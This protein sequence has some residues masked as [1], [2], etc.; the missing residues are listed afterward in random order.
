MRTGIFVFLL[1]IGAKHQ[2]FIT[3]VDVSC[4]VLIDVLYQIKEAPFYSWF[5]ECFHHEK[6]LD[7]VKYFS[8]ICRG[9]DVVFFP[10][11]LFHTN[12]FLDLYLPCI[13]GINPIWSWYILLF[14]CC[15]IQL[16]SIFLRILASVFL[17]D[18][19]LYKPV[20]F[21]ATDLRITWHNIFN[22]IQSNAN[23]LTSI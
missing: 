16:A 23:V 12:W 20:L 21:R 6:V 3:K 13:L 14:A 8:Y 7:F 9:Y 4:G 15:W 10:Y 19:G 11:I 17:R 22:N 1:A 5:V 2:C 18:T